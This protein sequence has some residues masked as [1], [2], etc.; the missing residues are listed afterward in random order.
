MTVLN[1]F[2]KSA[3]ESVLSRI[4]SLTPETPRLWGKMS[5]NQMLAHLKVA[6]RVPLSETALPRMFFGRLI[7]RFIKSKLYNDQPYGRSLPTAP[8]FI[9]K[10]EPEFE[11]EKKELIDLIT[12]FYTKGPTKVGQH[13]HPFFG[14]MTPEQWGLSMWK[15][16][17]HHLRQFGA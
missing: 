5:V 7:G 14:P 17:D 1:L 8:E 10:N 6:F 9:I 4:N 15:H 3:Y 12:T 2:D 13:P 16:L 11:Q